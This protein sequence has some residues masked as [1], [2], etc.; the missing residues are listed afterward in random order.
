MS[1]FVIIVGQQWGIRDAIPTRRYDLPPIRYPAAE[2]SRLG[3]ACV[4]ALETVE[5]R[6]KFA[7]AWRAK[8]NG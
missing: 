3:W 1:T 2:A 5:A 8:G 4:S 7:H 6:R